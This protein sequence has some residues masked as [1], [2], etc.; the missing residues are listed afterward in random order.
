[1]SQKINIY[2][3]LTNKESKIDP[4]GRT[5]KNIYKYMI[6]GQGADSDTILPDDLT[7]INNRF[8]RVKTI[9]D[10]SNVRRIL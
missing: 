2:N 6:V 8:V 10:L 1:M 9:E 4:Y 5:A 7:F 3:P